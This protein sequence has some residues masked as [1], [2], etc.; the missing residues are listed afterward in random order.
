MSAQEHE[1][2][3]ARTPARTLAHPASRPASLPREVA[4]FLPGI[5]AVT[6]R[7]PHPLPRVTGLVIAVLALAALAWGWFGRME[8]VTTGSG[9]VIPSGRVKLV[10][11]VEAGVVQAIHVRDGQV[12][13]AGDLLIS[14]DSTQIAA[15]RAHVAHE[16]ELAR[17]EV[18]KLTALA[19]APD[20][21]EA[22]YT[23]PPGVVADPGIIARHLALLKARGA[24]FAARRAKL[25]A[26]VSRR[27]AESQSV[28]AGI[29]RLEGALPLLERRVAARQSLVATQAAAE[30]ALLELRQTLIEQRGDLA[31]QRARLVE[32]RAG[33]VSAQR[34]LEQAVAEQ[35]RQIHGDL[36][37][38][39]RR[40]AQ[41]AQDLV[42]LDQRLKQ[43][44]LTAPEAGVVQQSVLHT[45][46]GVVTPAQT[47]L[48]IVP[49]GAPLEVEAM[50]PNKDIGFVHA[51]QPCQ[52]KLETFL[53][54]RYGTIPCTVASLSGDAI[55]DPRAPRGEGG[56][57]YA[58][59]VTLARET[60]AIDGRTVRLTPGMS[61][62]VEV[63][64]GER[65]L[66]DYIFAPV[67]KTTSE[68]MRE[69]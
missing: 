34:D 61:A 1:T 52:V 3:P 55:D 19:L 32:M 36:A 10:Q 45:V 20:A 33:V 29:A 8:V 56:P 39:E 58:A 40:Q 67:L 38:A 25:A 42:K 21:P 66:I 44:R 30:M 50:I 26:D 13:A 35:Q 6:G 31:V 28:E 54:T 57:A 5:Q 37:E 11:A 62:S 16:L 9:K 15:D 14:F 65:R 17:L 59:R 24:E 63:R 53:F 2:A 7:A 64:I 23:P 46:G 60:M 51:G 12:V 18:A 69:R 22:H 41:L 49:E 47:L 43:T 27:Q 4:A 68:A 48:A